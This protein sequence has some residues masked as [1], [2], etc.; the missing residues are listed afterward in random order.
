MKNSKTLAVK[1]L[2]VLLL[3]LS[4]PACEEDKL[5]GSN[6]EGSI[7][8]VSSRITGFGTPQTGAGATLTVLGTQLQDVVRVIF[9]GKVV[10]Q[11]IVATETSVSFRVPTTVSL[12]VKQ[13]SLLFKGNLIANGEIEVIPLPAL[14]YADPVAGNAGTTV[15]LHGVNMNTITAVRV[16]DI[17][18]TITGTPTATTVTFT[19]PTGATTS[20]I[21]VE[22]TGGPV[23][24]TFD[25]I[26]CSS[27]PSHVQC[28]PVLNGNLGFENGTIGGSLGG[29][30]FT[31]GGS[32][33]WQIIASPGG[34]PGL[35]AKTLQVTVNALEANPASAPGGS[36]DTWRIQLVINGPLP[37]PNPDNIQGFLVTP[38][39]RFAILGR[40]WADQSGRIV[41]I[42]GGR[43]TPC[44]GDFSGT[45]DITLSSG[46]NYIQVEVQHSAADHAAGYPNNAH[47]SIQANI[48]YSA[49]LGA[50][51]RFDDFRM[52][53]IG[54]RQ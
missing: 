5:T 25:F 23:Q 50:V 3:F 22:S 35:G 16:G 51:L 9:D 53:D 21:T 38:G 12:G 36:G 14:S 29:D 1:I 28:L 46:W 19:V 48:N 6:P 42:T 43:R 44:C 8:D 11:N 40:I 54:P 41:R 15:I 2:P 30:L 39:R 32:S 4:M 45:Q 27:S 33:V 31:A 47:A 34:A 26:V 52:V 17:A 7:T 18:A 13:F 10:N 37:N 24:S 49:N 20:K